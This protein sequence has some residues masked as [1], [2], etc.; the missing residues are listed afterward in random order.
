[1]Q[2]QHD[3]TRILKEWRKGDQEALD[4]LLPLV[5]EQLKRMARAWLRGERRDH[6]LNTTAMV[7]ETYLKMVDI[8]QVQWEH[9]AHF[10][11]M[12]SRVMRR[13]LV[14]YALKRK[15]EKRGGD[16]RRVTYEEDYLPIPETYAETLLELDDA[17]Q[18]MA[19]IHPRQSEAIELHYFGGLT[20]EEAGE[21]L[22]VSPATVMRDLRFGEAWLSREWRGDLN[23]PSNM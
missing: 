10:L 17:L 1:M 16:R 5:Y 18:Q 23:L 15:A 12:A 9:R 21:V 3:V 2:T 19:K 11:A 14:N 8:N 6:T 4:R 7:H 20:L 13:I 22:S